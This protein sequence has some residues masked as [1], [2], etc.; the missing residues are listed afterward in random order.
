MEEQE[1]KSIQIQK[2]KHDLFMQREVCKD[3]LRTIDTIK[4]S[5][6]P[7]LATVTY[8]VRAILQQNG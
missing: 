1:W 6:C 3:V 7:F 5:T 2:E 4:G 8:E